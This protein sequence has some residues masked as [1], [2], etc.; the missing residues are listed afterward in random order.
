[1]Q[2]VAILGPTGSGKSSLALEL[3]KI[4]DCPIYCIDSTTV[5]RE[6]SIGTAKPTLAEQA[7]ATHLMLDLVS[8]DEHYSFASFKRLV[9]EHLKRHQSQGL[10]RVILVG[11]THLYLKGILEGY[12][13]SEVAPQPD[14]REWAETQPLDELVSQL[15][16]IDP[17]SLEFVDLKNPRRVLR[18]LE[19]SRFG[20]VLFSAGYTKVP[21][22]YPIVRLGLEC[23]PEWLH[24]RLRSRISQMLADGWVQEVEC[25]LSRGKRPEVD[26][27][28]VLGYPQILE[29]I[30]ERIDAVQ[31]EEQVFRSTL[32]LVRKQLV[33]YRK[34][35]AIHWLP[36]DQLSSAALVSRASMFAEAPSMG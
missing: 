30:D 4:W 35:P 28:Q 20:E 32:Q 15:A 1:M 8:I 36:V 17:K 27:L 2:I 31:F 22:E 11:G 13:L 16:D 14:F 33:W 9:E 21:L 24:P 25:L 29:L 26:R 7:Q 23:P 12:S 10:A 34:E 5:Y 19:V 18:A 3:A 6:L